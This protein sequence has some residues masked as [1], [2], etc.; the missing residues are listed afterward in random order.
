MINKKL[1]YIIAGVVVLGLA[2][3]LLILSRGGVASL[4]KTDLNSGAPTTGIPVNQNQLNQITG[5]VIV[6][7]AKT[8]GCDVLG[9]A[10]QR[11]I[12]EM[13]VIT[14]QAKDKSDVT[15]CNQIQDVGFKQNCQ[16]QFYTNEAIAKKDTNICNKVQNETRKAQCV[17]YVVQY[18]K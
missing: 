17:G 10:G 3:Y 16:D 9:D 6:G 1:I 13:N 15:L 12:C 4:G 5:E 11:A 7:G 18:S 14:A 2:V 8:S